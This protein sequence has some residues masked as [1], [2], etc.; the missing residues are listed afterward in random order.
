MAMVGAG[1]LFLV[2]AGLAGAGLV[3]GDGDEDGDGGDAAEISGA[4]PEAAAPTPDGAKSL[5]S[6]GGGTGGAKLPPS[7]TTT[8]T[9]ANPDDP[10]TTVTAPGGDPTP[11]PPTAPSP[12]PPRPDPPPDPDPGPAPP[13]IVFFRATSGGSCSQDPLERLVSLEWQS[14]GGDSASLAGPEGSGPVGVSGT[15]TMCLRTPAA[16]TLTVAGPGGSDEATATAP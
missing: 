7:S 12:P 4:G 11:P 16:F 9:A 14:S 10:A 13:V 3:G 15:A 5:P 2:V 1:V 6:Q 8:T